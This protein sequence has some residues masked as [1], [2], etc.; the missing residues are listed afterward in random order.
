VEREIKRYFRYM[1]RAK[2]IIEAHKQML[3]KELIQKLTEI[4]MMEL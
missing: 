3:K 4:L 2:N 1:S